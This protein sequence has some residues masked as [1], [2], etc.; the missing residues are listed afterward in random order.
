[1]DIG[2]FLLQYGMGVFHSVRKG[3]ILLHAIA[4]MIIRIISPGFFI[5]LFFSFMQLAVMLRSGS[6][7]SPGLNRQSY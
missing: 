5:V 1:M 3:L 4:A 6:A 2:F 7:S